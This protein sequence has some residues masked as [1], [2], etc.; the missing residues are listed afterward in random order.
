[1]LN[2]NGIA[3]MISGGL[4]D[5]TRDDQRQLQRRLALADSSPSRADALRRRVAAIV[6]G[7]AEAPGAV[8]SLSA[9]CC[10]A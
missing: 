7:R 10:A 9:D 2:D 5:E 6:G 1:M 8:A 3:W 4:R